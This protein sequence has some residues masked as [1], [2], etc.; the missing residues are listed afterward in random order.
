M[1]TNKPMDP[2]LL[3]TLIDT[4]VIDAKGINDRPKARRCPDCHAPTLAAWRDG[5]FETV[6]VDP[7]ILTPLGE[8][9]AATTGRRTFDHWHDG[10]DL[11]RPE[12]ITA[13]HAGADILS[14]PI[15]PEHVCHSPPLDSTPDKRHIEYDQP[16]Y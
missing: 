1:T 5:K 13:W 3:G 4:A 14:H 6:H 16:P 15:R 12:A 8:L 11:R 2:W 7:V 9:Q 10:L